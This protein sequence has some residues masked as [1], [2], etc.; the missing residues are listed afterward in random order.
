MA[1]VMN[2]LLPFS[3]SCRV[4][5]AFGHAIAAESGLVMLAP[6]AAVDGPLHG[7]VDGCPVP[8]DEVWETLEAEPANPVLL[9]SPDF[10]AP[11]GRLAQLATNGWQLATLPALHSVVF[12]HDSGLRVA[13][14]ADLAFRE[15]C[16]V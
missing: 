13:M 5:R 10:A 7:L 12:C 6:L 2:T 9:D 8:W 4:Y 1:I 16:H 11:V 14:T 15:V 3:A